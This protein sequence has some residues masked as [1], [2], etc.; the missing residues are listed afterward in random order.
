M[1]FDRAAAYEDMVAQLTAERDKWKAA[2]S[3][4]VETKSLL[5]DERQ[6]DANYRQMCVQLTAERDTL[7]ADYD[8]LFVVKH[9]LDVDNERLRA[10]LRRLGDEFQGGLL[11]KLETIDLLRVDNERLRAELA[12]MKRI[13]NARIAELA[14]AVRERIQLRALR[15]AAAACVV[16][17][18]EPHLYYPPSPT[19]IGALRAVLAKVAP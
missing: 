19:A 3:G 6:P 14:E 8:K 15:E 2:V 11:D 9:N 10:E 16:R 18:S 5:I 12:E 7:Q 13:D 1:S 4:L 17:G